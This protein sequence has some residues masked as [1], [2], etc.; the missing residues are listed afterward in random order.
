MDAFSFQI[1]HPCAGIISGPSGSGKTFLIAKMLKKRREIF[2]T[3]IDKVIYIYSHFQDI[4]HE[5]QANDP[6][7]IFTSN[8]EDMQNLATTPCLIICDDVM[9]S[10]KRG[11]RA[12]ELITRFFVQ[13][14]HHLSCSVFLVLQNLFHPGVR[15]ISIQSHFLI[16]FDQ[17][18]DRSTIGIVARQIVPGQS[19]FLVEAYKRAC[20]TRE[21]G[22]L[23]I[24]LSP[25]NKSCPY[26][27]RSSLF[28]DDEDCELYLP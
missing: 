9:D 10:M 20:E 4:F 28:P 15:E 16:L 23:V 2:D 6:G 14:S 3:P 27:V 24:D 17:P 12:Q 21:H 7:I 11:S 22:Y 5:L 1:K 18:R 19:S 26:W 25:R 13:S 8:I